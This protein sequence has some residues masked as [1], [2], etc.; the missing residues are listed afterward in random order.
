MLFLTRLRFKTE[1]AYI[2]VFCFTTTKKINLYFRRIIST[3]NGNKTSDNTFFIASKAFALYII[4]VNGSQI[5]DT[6]RNAR[7]HTH[8]QKKKIFKAEFR[9]EKTI[10]WEMLFILLF[11]FVFY[12]YC[13]DSYCKITKFL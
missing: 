13:S 10:V 8:I 5:Y 1:N 3:N 2:P 12:F 4:R 6:T 7:T 11:F 9:N